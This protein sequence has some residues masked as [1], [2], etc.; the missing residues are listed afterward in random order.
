MNCAV[1]SP[2]L[3]CMKCLY[4]IIKNKVNLN[5]NFNCN[6]YDQKMYLLI[7][8]IYYLMFL[9][10]LI[11]KTAKYQFKCVFIMSFIFGVFVSIF[12]VCIVHLIHVSAWIWNWIFF[13]PKIHKMFVLHYLSSE[14]V[15][16]SISIKKIQIA[17]KKKKVY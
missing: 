12:Q 2:F 1:F 4:Y 11:T 9:L 17:K 10:I 5:A 14:T 15:Q 3:K 7:L 13:I 16:K 6:L 8:F